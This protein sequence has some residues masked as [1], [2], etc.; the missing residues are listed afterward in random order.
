MPRSQ[1]FISGEVAWSQGRFLDCGRVLCEELSP[2]EQVRW[3]TGLLKFCM[4]YG[5]SV[6]SIEHVAALADVPSDWRFAYAA[7]SDVRA[8]TLAA[9]QAGASVDPLLKCM[10][11]VAENTAKVIFNASGEPAPFD[12]D[13]GWWLV[14]CFEK[15]L[16]AVARPEAA[17]DGRR[18]LFASS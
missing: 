9:E 2:E 11:Y 1:S 17:D 14:P 3:A 13:A 7:F 15:F 8:I 10:L 4:Q 6:P 5:P 16:Q 18:L 12:H